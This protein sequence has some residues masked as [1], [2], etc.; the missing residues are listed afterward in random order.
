MQ[1]SAISDPAS[2]A[3]SL[4]SGSGG[5]SQLKAED[6]FELLIQQLQFQDPLEPV[7]NEQLVGQISQIRD[8]EMNTR[9]AE[10]LQAL[11]GQQ[12]FGLSSA[13]IGKYVEG[14]ASGENGS[15]AAVKGVVVSVRYTPQGEPLLQLDTGSV[16]P[17]TRVDG[18]TTLEQVARNVIGLVVRG[19]IPGPDGEAQPFEGL[20]VDADIED[21]E[22]ILTLEGG[23]RVP[24]RYVVSGY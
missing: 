3:G 11:T 18:V 22:L 12:Q 7:S 6:F 1:A 15:G 14:T 2:A 24:F 5:F 9:L 8:L 23:Q 17:L 21:G 19:A 16:L 10:A 20:V 13:M 4:V